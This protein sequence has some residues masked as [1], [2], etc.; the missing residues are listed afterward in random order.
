MFGQGCFVEE[1]PDPEL[2]DPLPLLGV[3]VPGVVVVLGAVVVLLGV[4]DCVVVAAALPEPLVAAAAPEMPAITPPAP[5]TP[6]MST[7]LIV[8]VRFIGWNLLRGEWVIR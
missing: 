7:A 2:P 1:L 6:V 5:S 8:L 3:V 4:L